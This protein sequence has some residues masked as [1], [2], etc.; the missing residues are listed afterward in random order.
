MIC[1]NAFAKNLLPDAD[2]VPARGQVLLT[3][4][5]QNLPFNGTFHS[6][7]G[8][9][10]FRNLDNRVLL[11]GARNKAMDEEQTMDMNT[12]EFI[13]SELENYLTECCASEF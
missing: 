2:I 13:Q 7:E 11:G 8:F 10:Y 12:S 4:P 6:D 1:T 3:S 5:I 9:Y